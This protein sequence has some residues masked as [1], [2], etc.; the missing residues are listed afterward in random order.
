M[1]DYAMAEICI[2]HPGIFE[3]NSSM[4]ISVWHVIVVELGIRKIRLVECGSVPV[5]SA[6]FRCMKVTA[7]DGGVYK[8][9]ILQGGFFKIRRLHVQ[10][11]EIL[12][13]DFHA[14]IVIH[15]HI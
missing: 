5:A 4:A 14:I 10:T 15:R 12:I 2:I 7:V 11:L 9:D 13:E 3:V 8:V 1:L 6:N